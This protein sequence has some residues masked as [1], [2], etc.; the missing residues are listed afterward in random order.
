MEKLPS[1]LRN[2]HPKDRVLAVIRGNNVIREIGDAACVPPDI[3]ELIIAELIG[4]G[5]VLCQREPSWQHVIAKINERFGDVS[6]I[7]EIQNWR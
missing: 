4:E 3:T 1:S 5:A 2:L 6:L 7:K